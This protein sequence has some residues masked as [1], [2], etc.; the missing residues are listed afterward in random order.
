[1]TDSLCAVCA[2]PMDANRAICNDC[3]REFHLALR[4][5]QPAKDCGDA[6]IDEEVQALLFGCNRCLGNMPAAAPT[7]P[8]QRRHVRRPGS[9][10]KTVARSRRRAGKS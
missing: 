9:N 5:D 4:T 10:A 2:E 7:A 8:E 1:M 3:G 6:W